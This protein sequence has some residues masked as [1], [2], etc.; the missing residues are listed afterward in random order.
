MKL[1]LWKVHALLSKIV[2][3]NGNLLLEA[4][5]YNLREAFKKNQTTASFKIDVV[6]TT[7]KSLIKY[8]C[9]LS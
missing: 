6:I 2:Q 3:S 4:N 9:N 5:N 7:V 8:S 1:D